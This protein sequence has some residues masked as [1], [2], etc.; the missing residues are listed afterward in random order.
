MPDIET[1]RGEEG[2]FVVLGGWHWARKGIVT[3]E[4]RYTDDAPIH[5]AW[6]GIQPD[7]SLKMSTLQT[8][9]CVRWQNKGDTV[10][11]FRTPIIRCCYCTWS[12]EA[13]QTLFGCA[14]H[15]NLACL[16]NP[17]HSSFISFLYFYRSLPSGTT[18]SVTKIAGAK[19]GENPPI[20]ETRSPSAQ[21]AASPDQ[22]Y[23]MSSLM[24]PN[25]TP[26]SPT[27][28]PPTDGGT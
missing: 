23:P 19:N 27:F 9:I 4:V 8:R 5:T 16:L 22:T 24:P 25:E 3:C 2:D 15:Y 10:R 17:L 6:A 14:P 7:M 18:N 26:C 12:R 1:L 21:N 11:S 28:L 13:F 20:S